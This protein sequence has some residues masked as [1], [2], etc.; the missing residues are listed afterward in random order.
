MP[1]L[2]KVLDQAVDPAA[3]DDATATRLGLKTYSHGTTYN[4]GVAPTVT[5][6]SSGT[7]A[8]TR[9]TFTPYQVQDGTWRLR[10]NIVGSFSGT[11][12]GQ[13]A[14]V[15][16]NGIAISNEQAIATFLNSVASSGAKVYGTNSFRSF[17]ATA[18]TY[19]RGV[20]YSGDVE[21]ASKPTW[22]Y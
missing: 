18:S 17:L 13:F 1:T 5:S 10:F 6:S 2:L 16:V 22:A 15:N 11:S 7:W 9:S 12:S 20:Y 21:L 3:M 19:D 14:D 4:G 8:N